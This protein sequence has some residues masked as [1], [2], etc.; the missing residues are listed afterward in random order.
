MKG[1]ENESEQGLPDISVGKMSMG[2]QTLSYVLQQ[3]FR[4]LIKELTL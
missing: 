1:R 3:K 2:C 4:L